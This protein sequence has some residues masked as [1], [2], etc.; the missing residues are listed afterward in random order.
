MGYVQGEDRNQAVLFPELIDKYVGEDN[1]VR[2]IEVFVGSLDLAELGFNR[3]TPADLGRPGYHPGDMLRLYLYGY[4]NGIRS[5]RKLEK[6]SGR[7]LELMWLMRKLKPDFKT[8]ANFRKD[9]LEAIKKVFREFTVLC[10]Q[11]GL[12]GGELIGIDGTKI[13]AVN[14]KQRNFTVEKLAKLISGID[15]KIDEYVRGLDETDEQEGEATELSKEELKRRIEELSKR[16]EKYK[17]IDK[18][19]TQSGENQLSQTDPDSRLM[20]VKDGKDVCYNVQIA[21]DNKHKLIVEQEVTN[22]CDDHNEL[23]KMACRAKEVLGVQQVEAVADKGYYGSSEVKKCEEAGIT[24]YVAR[25]KA[26]RQGGVFSKD[27]FT[28][29][30]G[31]DVYVCPA[32][33]KLTYRGK[34]IEK[35]RGIKYYVASSCSDCALKK[36]CTTSAFRRIK[37]LE[38]E[39]VLERMAV[40]VRGHPEKLRLRSGLVE[41]PFGTI[42][43]WMNQGY[44]LMRTKK[45]VAAEFSLTALAYN[46][47]RVI[48]Q[49][50]VIKMIEA[51]E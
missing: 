25:R 42:K 7:N 39:E 51:I 15:E 48:T 26:G 41:H 24:V 20:K 8:I 49:V 6:E 46:I 11:M 17:Q 12:F 36:Q 13:K 5:S 21:V 37:R 3:A 32:A 45:K 30:S 10:K 9:N 22:A 23:A 34:G 1:P 19:M 50:G 27:E 16:K 31:E 18:Q 4:L 47:K 44:F 2:F 29:K 43:R 35:G 28:Y 38:D 14:S 40:R 33:E